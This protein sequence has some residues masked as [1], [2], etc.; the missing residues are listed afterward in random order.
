MP[1]INNEQTKIFSQVKQN[2]STNSKQLTYKMS[3]VSQKF[4][5]TQKYIFK[6]TFTFPALIIK[7][8]KTI[9]SY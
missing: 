5:V 4:V 2:K 3:V 6:P 9:C 1:H 8:T 7:K